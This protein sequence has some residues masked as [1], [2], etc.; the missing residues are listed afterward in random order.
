MDLKELNDEN[1]KLKDLNR[2]L[3]SEIN[4]L[5]VELFLEKDLNNKAI[6]LMKSIRSIRE[7]AQQRI[8]LLNIK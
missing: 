5:R 6:D 7:S 3:I 1:M 2:K 8:D 4:L